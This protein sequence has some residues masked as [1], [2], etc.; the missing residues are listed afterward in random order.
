MKHTSQWLIRITGILLILLSHHVCT[1][2]SVF[3]LSSVRDAISSQLKGTVSSWESCPDRYGGHALRISVPS[4]KESVRFLLFEKPRFLPVPDQFRAEAWLNTASGECQVDMILYEGSTTN[5][6]ARYTVSHQAQNPQWRYGACDLPIQKEEGLISYN[7][8]ITVKGKEVL[9]GGLAIH[10]AESLVTNGTFLKIEKYPNM[11]IPDSP[12]GLLGYPWGWRVCPMPQFQLK[13]AQARWGLGESPN[14]NVLWVQKE[15]GEFSLSAEPIRTG[16]ENADW[17][18]RVIAEKSPAAS[19]GIM[20]IFRQCGRRGWIQENHFPASAQ[21][22]PNE[23]TTLVTTGCIRQ[24]LDT[25]RIDLMLQFTPQENECR[26]RSVQV[27]KLTPLSDAMEIF[28]DQAGYNEN[29][30]TRFLVTSETFPENGEGRFYLTSDNRQAYEG[31]L[32][33]VGRVIGQ[34]QVDWG[35]Y[36]FEGLIPKIDPGKYTIHASLGSREPVT[37]EITIGPDQRL[38]ATG[39]LAYQFYSIQRCG[40]VVPGWHGLCHNDDAKLPD[41]TH[42]DATGGYHNA[43][44]L[45]KHMD[46][47]TPI[48]VY[49]MISAYRAHKDFFDRIDRDQNGRGDLLDEAVWGATWLKKMVDPKSGHIWMNVIS[50]LDS[51]GLPENDTDGIIGNGDDRRIT[52]SDPGYLGACT[53]AAWAVLSQYVTDQDY[54]SYA[55]NLWNVYEEKILTGYNPR[56]LFSAMELHRVTGKEQYRQAVDRMADNLLSL[57]NE[58]GWFALQPGGTIQY[59]ILDEGATPAALADYAL[60]YPDSPRIPKIRE[61][62]RRYFSWSF[63]MADNPFGLIRHSI[64][65]EPFY[66]QS[67]EEWFGGSNS[68]YS[69]VAWAAYLTAKLFA[70]EPEFAAKLRCHA[71]NQIHWLLGLNELDL[72]MLEGI[73]TSSRI[74]Y[75]HVYSEIP[76]HP[77]GDVPG[78]IPN[79]IVREPGNSDRPWFDLRKVPG[80]MPACEC[81]EPWLPHNAYYLLMLSASGGS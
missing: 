71:T 35:R 43:G 47:N 59:R 1:A 19:P 25:D 56:H 75:H 69:S 36:Y 42:V 41:G 54:L 4:G 9:L 62:L 48:S 31:T 8:E 44:D 66:L 52:T 51:Y 34:S 38:A 24:R 49:G 74:Y 80:S 3:T 21:D 61:S 73:G 40:C 67:R 15:E 12:K 5:E 50:D 23:N 7:I 30:P 37:R 32:M 18:A 22:M 81:A 13:P 63:T 16:D 64:G 10:S 72:C 39:E 11:Q 29:E 20:I 28:V 70:D 79:G 45:N 65:G 57:Q 2:A 46:D 17:V 58:A 14:G 33:P 55:E 27:C 6:R 60:Q 53:I 68:A 26:I 76:G 78:T 77:R